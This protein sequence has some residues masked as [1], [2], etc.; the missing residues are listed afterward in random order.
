MFVTGDGI[1]S[2]KA[3]TTYAIKK[4]LGGIMFWELILDSN[5]KGML[6]AIDEIKQA[7]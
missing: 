1:A 2:V 6:E 7:R 3:K 5:R 4:K